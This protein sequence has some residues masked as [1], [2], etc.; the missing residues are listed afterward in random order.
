MGVKT[1][2]FPFFGVQESNKRAY[3]RNALSFLYYFFHFVK[4]FSIY[5]SP[6]SRLRSSCGHDPVALTMIT[7]IVVLAVTSNVVL[8]LGMVGTQ[9]TE[10]MSA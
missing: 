10:K 3:S 5:F 2:L 9:L 7:T 6:S 1:L 4:S 8:S